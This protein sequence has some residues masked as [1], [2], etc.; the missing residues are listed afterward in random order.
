MKSNLFL[1]V[2]YTK[3]NVL[4]NHLN[5]SILT[6]IRLKRAN[7][8]QIAHYVFYITVFILKYTQIAQLLQRSCRLVIKRSI[9]MLLQSISSNINL[10]QKS[11][12]CVGMM[13]RYSI[14]KE[15]G[16]RDA[17]QRWSF[18]I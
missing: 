16:K 2:K 6:R 14:K 1:S 18:G 5:F 8:L 7:N 10:M 15:T 11:V 3:K 9:T 4:F 17:C 13:L 12:I